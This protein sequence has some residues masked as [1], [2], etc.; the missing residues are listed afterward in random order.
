MGEKVGGAQEERREENRRRCYDGHNSHNWEFKTTSCTHG[1]TS[2][3]GRS[4]ASP[5]PSVFYHPFSLSHY[6]R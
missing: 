5:F 4:L 6:M 3:E 2:G 1:Y